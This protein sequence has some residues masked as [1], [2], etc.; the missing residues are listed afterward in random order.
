MR[1]LIPAVAAAFLIGSGAANAQPSYDGSKESCFYVRDFTD[2]RPADTRTM[3]IRTN[4]HRFFRVTMAHECP[5]LT[6]P[7]AHL[8][9]NVRGPDS[10]CRPIDW[11]LKVSTNPNGVSMPCIVKSMTELSPAEVDAIPPKFKP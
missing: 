1:I 3:Y 9:M 4:T 8:V 6:W 7:Q 5:E 2:W 11:D 10:I